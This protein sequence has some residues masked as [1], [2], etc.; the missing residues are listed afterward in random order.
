MQHLLNDIELDVHELKCLAQALT[1]SADPTLRQVALRHISQLKNRLDS[2]YRMLE[3]TAPQH[4]AAEKADCPAPPASA[5]AAEPLPEP[6]PASEPE[7]APASAPILGERIRTASDLRHAISLNDSFR[8]VRELFD[9]DTA[10]MNEVLRQIGEA[11][12]LEYAMAIFAAEVHTDEENQAATD[13]IELLHKY[14]D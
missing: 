9:G 7:P 4:P 3:A 13:F 11:P 2:L 14:F 5:P 6:E 8:F 10:R 1:D 12:T